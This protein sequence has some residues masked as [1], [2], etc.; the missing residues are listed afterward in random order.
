MFRWSRWIA[1]GLATLLATVAPAPLRAQ[2][3]APP[4]VGAGPFQFGGYVGLTLT[5][6]EHPES[7]EKLDVGE[8]VAAL[9]AWGQI[10]PRA[11]YLVELDMAK[12][13]SETWTGRESD[14]RL[15]PARLYLEYT[16]SDLLR[17][18][19]GRFLTPAAHHVPPVRQ[20][21]HRPDVGRRGFGGRKGRR[22][23]ALL[24]ALGERRPPLR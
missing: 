18:R 19:V 1:A 2:L 14:Q 5:R 13:T 12:Q 22:V 15:A 7:A 8:L 4:V 24:G 21:P 16:A 9:M 20:E 3:P 11:S 23:R 6:P 17:V 10:S